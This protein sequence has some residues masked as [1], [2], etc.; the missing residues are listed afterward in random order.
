MEFTGNRNDLAEAIVNAANGV[1]SNPVIPVRAGICVQAAGDYV[2]FTGSDGDVTFTSFSTA[3]VDKGGVVTLPGKLLADI[4]KSLPDKEVTFTC[5]NG[6]A[7]TVTIS[8]G[9]I[10][11]RIQP[12]KD[13]Y[14]GLLKDCE[15]IGAI[16]SD[17]FSDA[18]KAVIPAA[19]KK[20]SVQALHGMLLDLDHHGGVLSMV[21]TDR[22]RVAACDVTLDAGLD[23][24]PCIIPPWAA[25]RFRRGITTSTIEIGWDENLCTMRS[26]NFTLTTRQIAGEYPLWRKFF[27]DDQPHSATVNTEELTGAVRRAQLTSDV[28]DPV[29]LSFTSPYLMVS[30]GVEN[31]TSDLVD[32][33]SYTG[34]TWT[35]LFGIP[36]LLDGL[37]GCEEEVTF[38]FSD[39]LKPVS[40]ISGRYRYTILPRRR[41]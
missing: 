19:S 7:D 20:D 34:E 31:S 29:E 8:C 1:P 13:P 10:D 27:P 36:Y 25:D 3:K 14:P 26:A 5:P 9:R 23:P 28:D 30:G 21:A 38:G 35:G 11:F 37:A 2:H 16:N 18:V 12:Y 40:L 32:C 17:D 41:T 4:I 33:P 39:P 6:G 22:Y 24:G 15:S